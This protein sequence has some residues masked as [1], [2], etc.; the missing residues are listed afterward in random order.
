MT[1]GAVRRE[2]HRA[3]EPITGGDLVALAGGA[4]PSAKKE[5]GGSDFVAGALNRYSFDGQ[6]TRQPAI[7]EGCLAQTRGVRGLLAGSRR[8]AE[9]QCQPRGYFRRI[10]LERWRLCSHEGICGCGKPGLVAS[11]VRDQAA[12]KRGPRNRVCILA[13]LDML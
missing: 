2:G 6:G 5:I 8:I 3:A 12:Q 7:V 9:P 4:A 11:V 10:R 1:D 13:L